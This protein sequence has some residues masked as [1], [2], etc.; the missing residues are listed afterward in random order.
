[1]DKYRIRPDGDGW[2]EIFAPGGRFLI[3][4]PTLDTACA[5]LR[6]QLGRFPE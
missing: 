2:F 1:M 5:W 4:K 6:F 3:L